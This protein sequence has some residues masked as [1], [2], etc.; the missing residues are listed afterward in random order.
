MSI[1]KGQKTPQK[2][3]PNRCGGH[4]ASKEATTNSQRNQQ[5][6]AAPKHSQTNQSSR[7]EKKKAKPHPKHK[8]KPPLAEGSIS[9]ESDHPLY[10]RF[11]N[12][13]DFAY[14]AFQ[15]L[16]GTYYPIMLV[17]TRCA[18]RYGRNTAII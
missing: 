15:I 14:I 3:P 6:K 16:V 4:R 10:R 2:R 17:I 12:H 5:H 9:L 7:K 1:K 18:V 11:Q 8:K 13:Q